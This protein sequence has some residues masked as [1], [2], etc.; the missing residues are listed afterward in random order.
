MIAR[1]KAT[2]ATIVIGTIVNLTSNADPVPIDYR[3]VV[4]DR[5]CGGEAGIDGTRENTPR[6]NSILK[7]IAQSVGN[8]PIEGTWTT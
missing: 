2:R 7:I 3:G 8:G 6:A 4:G 1:R 5:E